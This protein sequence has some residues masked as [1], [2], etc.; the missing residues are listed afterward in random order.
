MGLLVGRVDTEHKVHAHN[1]LYACEGI[2]CYTFM[3]NCLH[4]ICVKETMGKTA[5]C[6][7]PKTQ[8]QGKPRALFWAW[9][10][11]IWRHR[12]WKIRGQC[13]LSEHPVGGEVVRS[14]VKPVGRDHISKE[15]GN[16]KA[17]APTDR[18]SHEHQGNPCEGLDTRLWHFQAGCL[19]TTPL[20]ILKSRG[21][22]IGQSHA[23]LERKNTVRTL[24]ALR[25]E[26]EQAQNFK[27]GEAFG[28]T[29]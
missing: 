12:R 19:H 20:P 29:D 3:W 8:W 18:Y 27:A 17:R 16:C 23:T 4:I 10:Y 5:S 6:F 21:G 22:V 11:L 25:W 15:S 2:M 26:Q 24:W 7:Q 28:S 9:T 14:W 13:R 1:S